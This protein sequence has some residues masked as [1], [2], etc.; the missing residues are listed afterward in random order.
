MRARHGW[1]VGSIL[2]L[3]MP[4]AWA[5]GGRIVFTGAV[6]APTCAVDTAVLATGGTSPAIA[7][8]SCGGATLDAGASYARQVVAIDVATAADDRLLAYFAANAPRGRDG[9]PLA[10][11]IVRTYE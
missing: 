11:L 5:A 4:G 1:L 10:Q 7:R 2:A 8:R 9:Q 6:V 3:A